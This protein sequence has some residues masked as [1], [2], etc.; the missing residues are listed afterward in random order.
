M[1]SCSRVRSVSGARRKPERCSA[2]VCPCILIV[3]DN[4]QIRENTAEILYLHHFNV[5]AASN[6]VQGYKIARAANPDL[7]LCDIMRP[8]TGGQ[9]LLQRAR[10]NPGTEG[11]PIVFFSAET[12]GTNMATIPYWTSQRIS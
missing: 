2:C 7:I 1:W 4:R 8:E 9:Y 5:V 10:S 12:T 11:I 3:E 6:G